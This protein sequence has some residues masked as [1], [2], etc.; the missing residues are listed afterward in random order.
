MCEG[1]PVDSANN[2]SNVMVLIMTCIFYSPIIPAAIPICLVGIVLWYWS[3][4]YMLLRKHRMPTM[5]GELMATFFANMMPFVVLTWAIAYYV[6]ISK[7][8]EA[9]QDDF[10][11]EFKEEKEEWKDKDDFEHMNNSDMKLSDDDN[12]ESFVLSALACS[13]CCFL[14]PF[15]LCLRMCKAKE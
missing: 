5:Y 6:F 7:I 8:H 3:N 1:T 15:G 12:S 2:I 9:Y 13:I 14:C 4:K 11:E 10:L